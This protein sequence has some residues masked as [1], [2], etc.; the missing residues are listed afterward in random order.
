MAETRELALAAAEKVKI[1][2]D[3]LKPIVTIDEAIEEKS[4]F[5]IFGPRI[6]ACQNIQYDLDQS[7][8]TISGKLKIRLIKKLCSELL[9]LV[10][11]I[12]S[13]FMPV[14]PSSRVIE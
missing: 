3:V 4:F 7:D 1:T 13:T 6:Q 2:Y 9:G 11:I 5:P 10:Y 14:R 12:I 8:H